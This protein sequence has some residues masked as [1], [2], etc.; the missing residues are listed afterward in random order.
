M[1]FSVNSTSINMNMYIKPIQPTNLPIKDI[2]EFPSK[3]AEAIQKHLLELDEQGKLKEEFLNRYGNN[4]GKP[5]SLANYILE[6]FENR[7][8]LFIEWTGVEVCDDKHT[9]AAIGI[10]INEVSYGIKRYFLWKCSTCQYEWVA[11]P[12][13]RTSKNRQ[14]C[15]KCG[16]LRTIEAVHLR[17]ETLQHWCD[18]NGAY[19][20]KLKSEFMGKLEDGTPVTLGEISKGSKQKVWWHCSNPNCNHE[21]KTT[22]ASRTDG[23]GLG[24]PACSRNQLIKGVND[25]ETYCHQHPE[26][27]Y[28]LKE[29]VGF[30]ENNQPI[31]ASEVARANNKRVYWKCNKCHKRWLTSIGARTGKDKTGCPHCNKIGTSFPEQYIYHSLKQLFPKT[32]NR[33]KDIIKHYEYDIVIP[34]LN[35]C[36]EYS[37][38]GW[39]KDKLERDQDK[40]NNCEEN[41][42]HFLQ[43]YGHIGDMIDTEGFP[44]EDTYEKNQIIYRLDNSKSEHIKQ[45]QHI[46]EYI[47]KEYAPNHFIREINF[48]IVEQEANKIMNKA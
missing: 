34:E 7:K 28:I 30:D 38:Y 15:P 37:G 40:A 42:A 6:D 48:T 43:I 11:T 24:C 23:R 5:N 45:L 10:K 25:L 18:A 9:I 14:G 44:I 39:H 17:G 26:L 41:G 2:S 46:I 16:R 13:A 33:Q 32:Q 27:S 36:I 47:L 8:H 12:N 1:D 19:G 20:T 22:V 29:F 4:L 3:Q 21:W 35:L 31:L